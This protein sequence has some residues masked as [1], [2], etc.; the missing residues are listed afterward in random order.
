MIRRTALIMM[1]ALCGFSR[2]LAGTTAD[3]VDSSLL[4]TGSWTTLLARA[5]EMMSSGNATWAGQ[6]YTKVISGDPNTEDVVKA[7]SGLVRSLTK[8]HQYRQAI[9]F[10]EETINNTEDS[11][12]RLAARETYTRLLNNVDVAQRRAYAAKQQTK[13]RYDEIPWYNIFRIPEKLRIKSQLQDVQSDLDY[14]TQVKMFFNPLYVVN[15]QQEVVPSTTSVSSSGSICT[16]GLSNQSVAT[17][18]TG[19]SGSQYS[20]SLAFASNLTE[21]STNAVNGSSTASSSNSN[22]PTS[23]ANNNANANPTE[24]DSATAVTTSTTI[25]ASTTTTSSGASSSNANQ[26]AASVVSPAGSLS[27]DAIALAQERAKAIHVLEDELSRILALIPADKRDEARRIIVTGGG[28]SSVV[29]IEP[30]ASTTV[31]STDQTASRT[32]ST[33]P[34]LLRTLTVTTS[35][36]ET[37]DTTTS[38]G[39]VTPTSASE[40]AT[41]GASVVQSQEELQLRVLKAYRQF[42]EM[43]RSGDREGQTRAQ[44]EYLMAMQALRAHQ[45]SLGRSSSPNLIQAAQ[46]PTSSV[47]TTGESSTTTSTTTTALSPATSSQSTGPAAA[48]PS[49]IPVGRPVNDD[50]LRTIRGSLKER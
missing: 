31:S 46:N 2:I 7:I 20:T 6:L 26:S 29:P 38:S 42:Q 35:A 50:Y 10:L 49:S 48:T 41:T 22:S 30:T 5:D 18:L 37:A 34:C 4:S 12:I 47:T 3:S 24:A 11:A 44:S 32:S 17:A 25:S 39:T 13:A 23:V 1:L 19:Q 45:A 14:I 15:L 9:D 21:N 27:S 36:T 40:S 28:Y 43:M 16:P 8:E 33:L